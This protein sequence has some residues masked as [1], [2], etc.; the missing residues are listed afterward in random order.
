[1]SPPAR[2]RPGIKLWLILFPFAYGGVAINVFFFFLLLQSVGVAAISPYMALLITV[3]LS[4]PA[5][6]ISARWI[7]SLIDEAEKRPG[8]S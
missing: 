4:I 2:P 6:W 3:P 7:R 8:K 1:M 5:T